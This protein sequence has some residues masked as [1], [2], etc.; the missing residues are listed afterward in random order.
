MSKV[1]MGPVLL[2]NFI[3]T[4]GYTIAIPFLVFLVTRFGGDAV[5][6]GFVAA[7][8]STFQFVGAP[9]LGRWSD[10]Y[11]RR[12]IL[13]LSQFGTFVSWML[14]LVALLMPSTQQFR[15][16]GQ[17]LSLPLLVIVFARALDGLTGGN[18]SVAN[19][20]V[21]DISSDESRSR[22]FGRMGIASNMGMVLG[23]A[24]ASVLGATVWGDA[25]PVS[26]SA[27]I[28]LVG[29]FFIFYAL[30]EPTRCPDPEHSRSDAVRS[31]GQEHR[32]CHEVTQ[33]TL[34]PLRSLLRQKPIAFVLGLHF[35]VMLAFSFFYT[36]FPLNASKRLGWTVSDLGIFFAVLSL[37]LVLVQGPILSRLSKRIPETIL[38]LGGLVVLAVNFVLMQFS[39]TEVLYLA[40]FLFAVGNG[41]MWPSLIS[42]TSSVA[43]QGLQ[44][45]I[46]GLAGSA[47]SLASIG[48]L[49][50]GG[51]AYT[52][53]GPWTFQIPAVLIAI[54]ALLALP[55]AKA[56]AVVAEPRSAAAE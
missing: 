6:Y 14:F 44:G 3:G 45:A 39:Q 48:G 20:Y 10:R 54:A 38:I 18:I 56:S 7:T 51:I 22:N 34:P 17:L 43:G 8:Y 55:M 13:L 52:W 41:V 21:G 28:A 2:V 40:S 53:I 49:V 25:L 27:A 47:G 12:K 11:G 19:A 4:L 32:D 36:A 35:L 26:V 29:V 31:F 23:P 46:Q 9:I 15:L 37:M 1:S 5:V 24:L 33:S 16:G 30:P 50:L 42:L